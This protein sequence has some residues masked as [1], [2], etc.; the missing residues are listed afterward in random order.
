[1]HTQSIRYSSSSMSFSNHIAT[2]EFLV[3]TGHYARF[4][5]I[6]LSEPHSYKKWWQFYV[7]E[8]D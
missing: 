6:L 2:M 5:I 4:T 1:M 8:K 7:V 3:S